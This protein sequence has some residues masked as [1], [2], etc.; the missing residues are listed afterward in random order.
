MRH[1]VQRKLCQLWWSEYECSLQ[2]ASIVGEFFTEA[3]RVSPEAAA[4]FRFFLQEKAR[5]C[6]TS[7]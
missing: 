6:I 3:D 1:A 4:Q 5:R 2:L 7:Q